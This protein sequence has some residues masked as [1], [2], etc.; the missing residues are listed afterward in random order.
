MIKLVQVLIDLLALMIIS[1]INDVIIVSIVSV[2]VYYPPTS[3]YHLWQCQLLLQL[4]TGRGICI[5]ILFVIFVRSFSFRRLLRCI[6]SSLR[7]FLCLLNN[8]CRF[9]SKVNVLRCR[10]SS[11][12][13]ALWTFQNTTSIVKCCWCCGWRWLLLLLLV[14]RKIN[15]HY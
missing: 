1:L 14:T 9:L 8:Y 6:L 3:F 11:C 12:F 2:A 13:V 4:R 7:T 5:I 10:L 15:T